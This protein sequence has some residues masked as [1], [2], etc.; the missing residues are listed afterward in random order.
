MRIGDEVLIG[1]DSIIET[2][3]PW[4]V[5]IGSRAAIGMRVTIIGHFLGMERAF[6]KQNEFSVDIGEDT[7][8]GPGSLIL[9]NVTIGKGAVVAAGSVVSS[10][11]P[12]G[13][14]VQGNPA[15]AVARCPVPVKPGM[16]FEE[17]LESLE[18]LEGQI[19][20]S[21]P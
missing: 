12:P 16:P 10:S 8:I 2:S 17:F 18:P 19:G 15:R 20:V 11:V 21:R 3:Y 9:P 13:T 6:L 14:L 1:Y 4:L 7:W 5:S